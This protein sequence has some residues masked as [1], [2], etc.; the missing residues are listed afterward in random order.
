MIEFFIVTFA[1]VAVVAFL[2]GMAVYEL[3]CWEFED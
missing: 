3:L 2:L 1:A